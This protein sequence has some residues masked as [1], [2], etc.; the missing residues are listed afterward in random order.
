MTTKQELYQIIDKLDETQLDYAKEALTNIIQGKIVQK[1]PVCDL[2]S[3]E[4]IATLY[5]SMVYDKNNKI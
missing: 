4:D 2:G 5:Q 1:I 3:P